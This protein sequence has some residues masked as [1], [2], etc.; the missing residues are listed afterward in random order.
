M[1]DKKKPLDI[2][3]AVQI[4]VGIAQG[5]AYAHEKGVIHRDIK[6]ENILITEQG[7][8]KI[9]DWGMSR[10]LAST[11]PTVVGFSISYAA[12][13][14]VAPSQYGN[15][16][17][18]TD[19]FQLG[20]VFYELVT[21]VQPFRG[22][23]MGQVISAILHEDPDLPSSLV[24]AAIIVDPIILKCLEKRPEDRYQSVQEMF[25]DLSAVMRE[26]DQSRGP[27]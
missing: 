4:V 6:P 10:I 2:P 25:A 22:E 12:P 14:Q 9:T 7:I 20:V 8:P 23:D 27:S 19:I 5:L 16:D 13:E 26:Q 15:T 1:I 17:Q 11:M 21:G 3:S 18:R 24:P